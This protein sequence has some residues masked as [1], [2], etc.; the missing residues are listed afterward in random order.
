MDGELVGYREE[1]GKLYELHER[2]V[3]LKRAEIG[4]VFQ[5]FN[6]FPHMTAIENVTLAPVRV[7]K[8]SRGDARDRA[9]DL[10]QRVGLGDKLNTYPVALSG[11]Q[12]QR[13]AIAR[14]LAMQPKLMLF[15]E[16]TS[17]LDPELVGDVLDAMRQLARDG[18]TMIVVTHEMG[19]AREV[20]DTAVFMDEGVVVEAGPPG[21]V[22][23][24]PQHDRT[25]AFLSKV[26]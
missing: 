12:Q 14:A 9:A 15:D 25:K 19:F 1:G 26:L 5:H 4:M 23:V 6:L 16:P 22:L 3:A 24:S 21:N 10:L 13:V 17:A 18:M 2:D 11:G 20:A 8:V 7:G